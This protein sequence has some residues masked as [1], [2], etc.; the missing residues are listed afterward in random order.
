MNIIVRASVPSRSRHGGQGDGERE[1]GLKNQVFS[2]VRLI[3]REH[4]SNLFLIHLMFAS[5]KIAKMCRF[6]FQKFK[7]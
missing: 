7:N 3:H 1:Q 5:V 6:R 2:R 4:L